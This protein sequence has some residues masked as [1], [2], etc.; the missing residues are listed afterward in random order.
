MERFCDPLNSV[1]S[2]VHDVNDRIIMLQWLFRICKIWH[3]SQFIAKTRG[4]VTN[5][6]CVHREKRM[7][8]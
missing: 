7:M 3:T 2:L 8:R 5:I 4:H 6:F 1:Q